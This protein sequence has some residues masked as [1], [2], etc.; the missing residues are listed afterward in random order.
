MFAY[1]Y[2]DDI[3]ELKRSQLRSSAKST[4]EEEDEFEE[5]SDDGEFTCIIYRD[6]PMRGPCFEFPQYDV[7]KP[8]FDG[9]WVAL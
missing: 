9:D 1:Y 6:G 5:S 7:F 8:P 3:S 4:E 2:D